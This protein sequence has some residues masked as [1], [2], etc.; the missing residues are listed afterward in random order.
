MPEPTPIEVHCAIGEEPLSGA[1]VTL[2]LPM[3]LKNPYRLLFG[4]ADAGG[5]IRISSD[6][7]R[8]KARAEIDFFPMDY[9]SFP[10]AWTGA[11]EVDVL[12]V[13]GVHRVRS[14]MDL[15]GDAFY[16]PDF[17][18]VL[19]E[20]EENLH[21]LDLSLLHASVVAAT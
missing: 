15:W 16:P 2:T 13:N 10:E 9:S 12:D 3:R 21:Q 20:Y 1:W 6:E 17:N 14:A 8:A 18:R 5:V 11:V 7:L 4:P 19:T